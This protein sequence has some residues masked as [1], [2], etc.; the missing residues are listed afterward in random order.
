M[1]KDALLLLSHSDS[2]LLYPLPL[3]NSAVPQNL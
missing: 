1:V 3:V 2:I